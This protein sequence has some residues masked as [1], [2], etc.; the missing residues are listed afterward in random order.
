MALAT[1]SILNPSPPIS[2]Y[3]LSKT[4][5][6]SS[7][8]LEPTLFKDFEQCLSSKNSLSSSPLHHFTTSFLSAISSFHHMHRT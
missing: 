2:G 5:I 6:V 3:L 8:T 7:Y 4:F 1:T